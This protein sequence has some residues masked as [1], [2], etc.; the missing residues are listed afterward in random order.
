MSLFKHH[1]H[2]VNNLHPLHALTRTAGVP[3]ISTG[4]TAITMATEMPSTRQTGI[5]ALRS[6]LTSTTQ[7][8]PRTRPRPALGSILENTRQPT[9]LQCMFT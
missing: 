4:G 3:L 5:R 7:R 9:N 1:N 8:T 6:T 2:V